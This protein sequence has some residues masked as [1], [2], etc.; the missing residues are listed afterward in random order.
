MKQGNTIIRTIQGDIT[1]I[2]FVEAIVNAANSKGV[3]SEDCVNQGTY[4]F[5]EVHPSRLV[6]ERNRES[7]MCSTVLVE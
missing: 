5:G 1:K 4:L 6:R 2:D 7:E 3:C